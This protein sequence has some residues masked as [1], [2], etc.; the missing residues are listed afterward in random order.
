MFAFA[1]KS[2][3]QEATG[4][5]KKQLSMVACGCNPS[6]G[7]AETGSLLS[8]SQDSKGPCL[9]GVDGT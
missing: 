7:E 3:S 1:S 6:T 5:K 4:D 9:G 8:K 2:D